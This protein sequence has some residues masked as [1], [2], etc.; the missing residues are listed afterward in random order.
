MTR[1]RFNVLHLLGD[2][3]NGMRCVEMAE[4]LSTTRRTLVGVLTEMKALG[5]ICKIGV[6]G[7][8]VLWCLP[9]QAIAARA[10][11]HCGG[12]KKQKRER[13]RARE[14][15]LTAVVQRVVPASNK[16]AFQIP[17]V[18]SIWSLAA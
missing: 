2:A 9:D 3:G 7:P 16:R 1:E 17:A 4:A 11:F 12:T 14:R 10:R 8:T 5:L 15:R 13:M 6:S 18:N